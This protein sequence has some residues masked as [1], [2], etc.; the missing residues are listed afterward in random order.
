MD[1]SKSSVHS[2]RSCLEPR[3]P[4]TFDLEHARRLSLAKPR[5]THSP[6]APMKGNSPAVSSSGGQR[7]SSRIISDKGSESSSP[8][9]TSSWRS[10]LKW[11]SIVVLAGILLLGGLGSSS[12]LSW[13]AEERGNL[14][15]GLR[16]GAAQ[17]QILFHRAVEAA[18]AVTT[19]A[20]VVSHEARERVKNLAGASRR[21]F[22]FSRPPSPP[23]S[24]ENGHHHSTSN[25]STEIPKGDEGILVLE[26]KTPAPTPSVPSPSVILTSEETKATMGGVTPP[27]DSSEESGGSGATAP[28]MKSV[29]SD[30]RMGVKTSIA[31]T[32]YAALVDFFRCVRKLHPKRLFPN[33][34]LKRKN[35]SSRSV[36]IPQHDSHGSHSVINNVH[37]FSVLPSSYPTQAVPVAE[38]VDIVKNIE[39]LLRAPFVADN[40]SS[41]DS[42]SLEK[43]KIYPSTVIELILQDISV[44]ATFPGLSSNASS[45]FPASLKGDIYPQWAL[46]ENWV[47]QQLSAED[48]QWL[49]SIP[50]HFCASRGSSP[51]DPV[52][53]GGECENCTTLVETM[54]AALQQQLLTAHAEEIMV[55]KGSAETSCLARLEKERALVE[56]ED[57]TT[58]AAQLGLAE[59]KFLECTENSSAALIALRIETEQ[60][61]RQS[62][63]ELVGNVSSNAMAAAAWECDK[64]LESLT[65][66]FQR[67]MVTN[68][69]EWERRMDQN[70]SLERVRCE[71]AVQNVSRECQANIEAQEVV[72]N[73][74]LEEEKE[75]VYRELHATMTKKLEETAAK[76]TAVHE[77]VIVS[78]KEELR[79]VAGRETSFQHQCEEEKKKLRSDAAAACSSSLSSRNDDEIAQR[80]VLEMER[81]AALLRAGRELIYQQCEALCVQGSDHR[82]TTKDT[83]AESPQEIDCKTAL[84]DLQHRLD[85]TSSPEELL[86]LVTQ[87]PSSST[88]TTISDCSLAWRS[89]LDHT[90]HVPV[91]RGFL[92]RLC[93]SVFAWIRQVVHYAFLIG[94]TILLAK[95]TLEASRLRQEKDLLQEELRFASLAVDKASWDQNLKNLKVTQETEDLDEEDQV[96]TDEKDTPMEQLGQGLTASTMT[97]V[98]PQAPGRE[99]NMVDATTNTPLVNPNAHILCVEGLL[100][101]SHRQACDMLFDFY[102]SVQGLLSESAAATVCAMSA[103]PPKQDQLKPLTAAARVDVACGTEG[104]IL[105]VPSRTTPR[106]AGIDVQSH[107]LKSVVRGYFKALER[108]YVD[109]LEAILSRELM[110]AEQDNFF[111]FQRQNH[112]EGHW[113]KEVE[114]APHGKRKVT[115]GSP[116][117]AEA[118]AEGEEDR[119]DCSGEEFCEWEREAKNAK[120]LIEMQADAIKVLEEQLSS[121]L[122]VAGLSAGAVDA[123]ALDPPHPVTEEERE[124]LDN[125]VSSTTSNIEEQ[126]RARLLQE[127]RAKHKLQKQLD[128]LLLEQFK[129]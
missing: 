3:G 112:R 57:A 94:G 58:C 73:Q 50:Q 12:G 125:V 4:P 78:L 128:L 116:P 38:Q 61:L 101:H 29:S 16:S 119:D 74:R 81:I 82:Q 14:L 33:R 24:Q 18:C 100:E 114:D 103:A 113:R 41:S 111:R 21:V 70:T 105:P 1:T 91:R 46:E 13:S 98:E 31:K 118:G 42:F 83:S 85:A 76:T 71:D 129:G 93:S 64:R 104:P 62:R 28:G 86:R 87:R 69:L 106:H 79:T 11:F 44:N 52:R 72:F 80:E 30:T 9:S 124:L 63:E 34:F 127:N 123:A 126:L 75:K 89:A 17:S 35:S 84:V 7:R 10:R 20:A 99:G 68:R 102:V 49:D 122:S 36:S 47:Y 60:L 88:P 77:K 39:Q 55:V 120:H 48:R 121:V 65:T 40:A 22:A 15:L 59:R 32:V 110:T 109:L 115:D 67:E 117:S 66:D 92:Q 19:H 97:V 107:F 108:Y 8:E 95:K 45:F 25:T 23:G 37:V 90:A 56:A 27:G 6:E 43:V 5:K 96:K 2:T 53:I 54:R 26:K 51:I